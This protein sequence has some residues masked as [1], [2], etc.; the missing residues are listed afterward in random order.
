MN[1]QHDCGDAACGSALSR[2]RLLVG[3][4]AFTAAMRAAPGRAAAAARP[5]SRVTAAAAW[6]ALQEG[7]AR[8]M[9]DQP[10]HRDFSRN[11]MALAQ[12][13][14]PVAVV[15]GCGDSRVSPELLFDQSP[16][17]LFVVRVAGNFVNIDGLA[18]IEYAVEYLGV[19]LVVVLGHSSCGAVGAAI[20]V[21]KDD[22]ELPGHLTTLVQ[23]M[24]RSINEAQRTD[25]ANLLE[26]AIAINVRHQKLHIQTMSPLVG[27]YVASG[28]V[29]VA[30]GVYEIA[31][32]KVRIIA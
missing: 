18:S 12:G 5:P 22:L 26:A 14:Q 27:K 10:R 25:P 8:Y 17:D 21:L 28:E 7:N 31:T 6:Q 9:S 24:F 11:R 30:G 13:Q 19:P 23:P 29:Q 3:G 20:K 32:G 15:L 2:R 16:G 1:E 4:A